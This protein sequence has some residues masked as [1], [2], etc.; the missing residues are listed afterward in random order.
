[1]GFQTYRM[2]QKTLASSLRRPIH[3]AMTVLGYGELTIP[4][5][6]NGKV[7]HLIPGLMERYQDALSLYPRLYDSLGRAL[8]EGAALS[9]EF[10]SPFDIYK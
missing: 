6:Q 2:V 3:G 9:D 5:K 7:A 8:R 10:D 1:M 4:K